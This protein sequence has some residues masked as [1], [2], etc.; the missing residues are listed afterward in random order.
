MNI[1]RLIKK[2]RLGWLDLTSS[3]CGGSLRPRPRRG[4]RCLRDGCLLCSNCARGL[5]LGGNW[6]VPIPEHLDSEDHVEAETGDESVENQL[7]IDLLEGSK[8]AGQG[9]GEIVKDL[10]G[11]QHMI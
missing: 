2:G 6:G 7:I 1:T 10:I 9:A 11:N 3:T 5:L 8:D 4:S